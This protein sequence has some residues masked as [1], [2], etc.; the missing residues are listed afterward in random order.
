[1]QLSCPVGTCL[2]Q[3]IAS[4]AAMP[5][6]GNDPGLIMV[7]EQVIEHLNGLFVGLNR[8]DPALTGSIVIVVDVLCELLCRGRVVGP[9]KA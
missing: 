4:P 1:M 8:Q 6:N 5:G 2:Q 3:S 7:I 9:I